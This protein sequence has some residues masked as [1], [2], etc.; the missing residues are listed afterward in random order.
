MIINKKRTFNK[1]K[2]PIIDY[3]IVNLYPF[4]KYINSKSK[5]IIEMIDISFN[6]LY[7]EHLQHL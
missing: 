4:S 6:R 1:L 7:L 2:F 5:D 3:V